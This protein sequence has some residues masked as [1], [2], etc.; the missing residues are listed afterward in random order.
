MGKLAKQQ[1]EVEFKNKG[2]NFG[3]VE[4]SLDLQ[5]EMLTDQL[6]TYV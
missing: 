3:N 4:C 6:D 1:M 5:I 2:I